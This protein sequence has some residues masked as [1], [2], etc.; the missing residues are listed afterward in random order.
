MLVAAL[1]VAF[2]ASCLTAAVPG[3]E[4]HL[5]IFGSLGIDSL[6]LE[7]AVERVTIVPADPGFHA[8]ATE[9]TVEGTLFFTEP[10]AFGPRW[11]L[12]SICVAG[13]E[14]RLSVE[15]SPDAPGL[16]FA[17]SL[18]AI[19]DPQAGLSVRRR[20]LPDER[21]QL[22]T[23]LDAYRGTPWEALIR[24]RIRSLNREKEAAGKS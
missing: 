16:F 14:L 24:A 17:G 19:G 9:A 1:P 12:E 11:R 20:D 7:Q 23:L 18:E 2:L 3:P 5:V 15:L 10:L 6:L 22:Q 13:E 21:S 8:A 4:D